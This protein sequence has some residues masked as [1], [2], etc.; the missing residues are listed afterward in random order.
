M[1]PPRDAWEESARIVESFAAGGSELMARFLAEVAEAIRKRGA[2]IR[3]RVDSLPH[4]LSVHSD[5]SDP[6]QD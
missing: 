2:Q 1:K 6:D 4:H 5:V 3:K